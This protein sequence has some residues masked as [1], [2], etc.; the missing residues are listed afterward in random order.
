M[1]TLANLH[2]YDWHIISN[3]VKEHAAILHEYGWV[4]HVF[5]VLNEEVQPDWLA[6]FF[7]LEVQFQI[8]FQIF[9][10]V[11]VLED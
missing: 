6:S 1:S 5:D 11:Q 4:D 7:H 8:C 2:L 9:V 10:V 3:K